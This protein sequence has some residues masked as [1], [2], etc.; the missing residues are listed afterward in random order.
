MTERRTL[1]SSQIMRIDIYSEE[2]GTEFYL[3]MS[4]QVNSN[5]STPTEALHDIQLVANMA[6]AWGDSDHITRYTT[7]I[8]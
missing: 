5:N 7:S 8:R 1:D 2:I 6:L 3:L 4:L